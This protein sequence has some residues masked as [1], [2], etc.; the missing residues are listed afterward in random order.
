MQWKRA[1]QPKTEVYLKANVAASDAV[2]MRCHQ[3]AS[4]T[5]IF[6]SNCQLSA[7]QP[8]LLLF[9]AFQYFCS[10]TVSP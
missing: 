4:L 10:G 8:V 2:Q 6:N 3:T 1:I 5:V 7:P 9:V